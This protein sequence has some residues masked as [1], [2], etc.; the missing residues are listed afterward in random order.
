[1]QL[2]KAEAGEYRDVCRQLKHLRVPGTATP[3]TALQSHVRSG[4]VSCPVC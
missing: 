2:R 4:S 3:L 1:M